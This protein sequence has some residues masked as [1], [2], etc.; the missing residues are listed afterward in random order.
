MRASSLRVLLLASFLL[1]VDGQTDGVC[2]D[3]CAD[4]NNGECNDYEAER[5][6][7]YVGQGYWDAE[8]DAQPSEAGFGLGAEVLSYG[9]DS[10]YYGGA[11]ASYGGD[12][13]PKDPKDPYAGF[14]AT[15]GGGGT[16]YG[17]GGSSR[18][19]RNLQTITYSCDVGTDCN[20]CG[21]REVMAAPP[22]KKRSQR[23]G[24][25]CLK[26]MYGNGEC[27]PACNVPE[28]NHDDKDCSLEEIELVCKPDGWS[29]QN[30]GMRSKPANTSSATLRTMG[31]NTTRALVAMEAR[32]LGLEEFAVNLDK[33]TDGWSIE[34]AFTLRLR[35]R[36]SRVPLMPCRGILSQK[37]EL[38]A[39]D[40]LVQRAATE[41]FKK[42]MLWFPTLSLEG[43]RL[44]YATKRGTA[45]EGQES[46]DFAMINGTFGY[47]TCQTP[48]A[49][50]SPA[51]AWESGEL[52][53]DGAEAC[54]DCMRHIVSVKTVFKTSALD[55]AFFPFDEQKF[56]FLLSV[57]ESR[58][59]ACESLLNPLNLTDEKNLRKLIGSEFVPKSI[60]AF[61]PDRQPGACQV[62]LTVRR[63]AMIFGV[64]QIFPTVSVVYACIA[65]LYLSAEDHTGD[66]VAAVLVGALILVVNFQTDIGL[67]TVHYLVWWDYFNLAGFAVLLAV[68]VVMLMEHQL[69][70][71]GQVAKAVEFNKVFRT[72]FMLGIY[73][74]VVGS[75]V[76][77]GTG[78]GNSAATAGAL[79]F[80]IIGMAG[81]IGSAY[82]V[83]HRKLHIAAVKRKK[84]AES[85]RIADPA[86]PSFTIEMAAIF[87]GFDV[88]GDGYISRNEARVM[89][90]AAFP[91]IF[92]KVIGDVLTDLD[93]GSAKNKLD[94]EHFM[95]GMAAALPKLKEANSSS[96]AASPS[97]RL[98]FLHLQSRQ[99]KGPAATVAT[100][101]QPKGPAGLSA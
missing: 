100:E 5:I 64:K 95:E 74:V 33:E 13:D 43:T 73:P 14:D 87:K 75:L 91:A 29:A 67:G 63:N 96:T 86:S 72:A 18:A 61:K 62:E 15:Y 25:H 24:E 78:V 21:P 8:L 58:L 53:P 2:E 23:T 55:L 69:Y 20:D 12:D 54:H 101:G 57:P 71:G 16:S 68:L 3:T 81:T 11:E 79:A 44:D 30:A 77:Y 40:D 84:L 93:L 9:G 60:R 22:C 45:K 90:R 37:L 80:F 38:R 7:N 50:T 47:S 49:K 59:F 6:E 19:R 99:P 97:G 65:A 17:G 94:K 76:V 89:L 10:G 4:A 34:A 51:C 56:G 70:L 85:L 41:T 46:K 52:P 48:S 1:C 26:S 27:D 42:E 35:W 83:Y 28:C 36:D 92:Y 32:L 31:T 39:T 66:R 82:C 88:D 98:N